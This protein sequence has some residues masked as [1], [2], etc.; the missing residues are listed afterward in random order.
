MSADGE[1]LFD[2]PVSLSPKRKWMAEHGIKLHET[3]P[4]LVGEPD[5]LTGEIAAFYAY[6]GELPWESK[7]MAEG[8]TEHE[9]L[10]KLAQKKGW[11]LWV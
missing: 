11:K 2:V 1:M 8:A 7:D 6:T 3:P 5:E 10:A 9:A 4:M